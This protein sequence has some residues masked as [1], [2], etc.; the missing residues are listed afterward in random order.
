MN[1][2]QPY[3]K[4]K[5]YIEKINGTVLAK[6]RTYNRLSQRYEY[7]TRIVFEDG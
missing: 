1:D 5:S 3:L 7:A 2:E 4:T 6:D